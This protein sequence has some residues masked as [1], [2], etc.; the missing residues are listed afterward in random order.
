MAGCCKQVEALEGT[1]VP[2]EVTVLAK[3]S[4]GEQKAK[5]GP[6]PPLLLPNAA[7]GTTR[8]EVTGGTAKGRQGKRRRE[9]KTG[10]QATPLIGGWAWGRGR[11]QGDQTLVFA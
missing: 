6:P 4:C 7:R 1:E 9:T 3:W 2:P 11:M 5:P 10:V 8:W